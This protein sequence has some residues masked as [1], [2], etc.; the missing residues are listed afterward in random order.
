MVLTRNFY[1]LADVADSLYYAIEDGC[2]DEAVFWMNELIAS[3]ENETALGTLLRTWAVLYGTSW[4]EFIGAVCCSSYEVLIWLLC[5]R[6][7]LRDEGRTLL[8]RICG[9]LPRGRLPM[10]DWL[11]SCL[12]RPAWVKIRKVIGGWAPSAAGLGHGPGPQGPQG[13]RQYTARIIRG[14]WDDIGIH[15]WAEGG[16]EER[17]RHLGNPDEWTAA[18]KNKSHNRPGPGPIQPSILDFEELVE[19]GQLNVDTYLIR[20]GRVA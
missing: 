1:G 4:P 8:H 5:E 2:Y 13:P 19:T 10:W 12:D 9:R 3:G 15:F 14:T 16:A 17:C 7:D 6:V 20:K 18:E 11:P